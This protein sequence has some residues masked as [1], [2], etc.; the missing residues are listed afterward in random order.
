MVG[1]ASRISE[2]RLDVIRLK[3]GKVLEDLLVRHTIRQHSEDI[4]DAHAHPANARTPAAFTRLD[5]D[6]F[7]KFHGYTLGQFLT[8]NK[9]GDPN[10]LANFFLS[11]SH[12]IVSIT[13]TVWDRTDLPFFNLMDASG[14]T[15]TGRTTPASTA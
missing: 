8:L 4:G 11:L 13:S 2:R 15:Q 12:Q 5:R 1:L 10:H 9:L 7:E 6:A 3:I 14:R